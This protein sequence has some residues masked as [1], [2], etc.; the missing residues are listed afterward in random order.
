MQAMLGFLPDAPHN[1]LYIDPL[2]PHWLP[3]LTVLD[4]RV[5]KHLIDI[6]F[7]RD[8]E[9]T[10]FEV[11]RGDPQVVERRSVVEQSRR[12]LHDPHQ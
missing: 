5:G 8:G 4:L 12:L 11:L 6:S 2:L 3:D 9:E 1:K 10:K 7:W